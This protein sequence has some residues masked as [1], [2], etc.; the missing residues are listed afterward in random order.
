MFKRTGQKP[1]EKSKAF[2]A[3]KRLAFDSVNLELTSRIPL[4][5]REY[6]FIKTNKGGTPFPKKSDPFRPQTL[7]DHLQGA[8]RDS[9]FSISGDDEVSKTTI[10][11]ESSFEE[12]RR[13]PFRDS[14]MSFEMKRK[15]FDEGEFTIT[16]GKKTSDWYH[17]VIDYKLSEH[18]KRDSQQHALQQL[19]EFCRTA[20]I[21][22]SKGFDTPIQ[23]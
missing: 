8:Q 9:V 4:G 1:R 19:E 23:L 22:I 2:T 5:D 3:T 17:P 11:S 20:N 12:L 21:K 6:G 10:S 13:C 15:R 16:R 18:S 14:E 7:S